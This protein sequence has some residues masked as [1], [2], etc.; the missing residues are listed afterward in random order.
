MLALM[1]L[2]LTTLALMTLAPTTQALIVFYLS[3][4]GIELGVAAPATFVS[5]SRV[6]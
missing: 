6:L 3:A 2:T 1:T 5:S 4:L